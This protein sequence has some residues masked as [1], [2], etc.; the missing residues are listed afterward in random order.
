MKKMIIELLENRI[1]SVEKEMTKFKV[2]TNE[3]EACKS[4]VM[5][6]KTKLN[7]L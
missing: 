4:L 3:H 5:N 6:L 2:D 7:L 1:I